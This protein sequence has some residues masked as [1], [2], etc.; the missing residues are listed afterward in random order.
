[1]CEIEQGIEILRKEKH[2]QKWKDKIFVYNQ[3]QLYK[4]A[5]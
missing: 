1:M 4:R 2:D 3:T 5:C